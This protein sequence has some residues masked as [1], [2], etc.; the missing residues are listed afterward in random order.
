VRVYAERC[1]MA[2]RGVRT[3]KRLWQS[4][5]EETHD[6]FWCTTCERFWTSKSP[7]CTKP[8]FYTNQYELN[9]YRPMNQYVLN[10]NSYTHWCSRKRDVQQQK[11]ESLANA[12]VNAREHCVNE[13][14]ITDYLLEYK[15]FSLGDEDSENIASERYENRHL[16]RPLTCLTPHISRIPAN[17]CITLILLESTFTGL[18]FCRWQY[19]YLHSFSCCSLPNTR[20]HAKFP[21]NSTLQQFK[22]IQGHRSWYQSKAHMWLLISH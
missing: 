11:Q 21:E 8:R 17:I 12:K 22:V 1:V 9:R 13:M 15:K 16:R 14:P 20:N 10:L 3:W 6:Q 4:R 2:W 5:S 19:V 7:T 18:H